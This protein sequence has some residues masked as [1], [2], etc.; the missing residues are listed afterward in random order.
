M[1]KYTD[2]ELK[3]IYDNI[4]I[5]HA[6]NEQ[7]N[8]HILDYFDK[9]KVQHKPYTLKTGDYSFMIK[10]IPKL[11]IVRDIYFDNSI[12]IERKANL[13]ELSNNI[14][15][16]RTRFT[17]EL[18]RAKF[19]NM[20]FIIALEQGTWGDLS[21]HRYKTKYDN[22][23]FI[24]TLNAFQIDY[25]VHIEMI[26]DKIAFGHYIKKK[27]EMYAKRYFLATEI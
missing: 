23:R 9:K 27:F 4:V 7:K 18:M 22:E 24:S 3:E 14:G 11:G 13:E 5:L 15:N 2:K 19:K 10:A 6:K 1:Y 20:L 26:N 16:D 12:A 21:W 8:K 25:N 17:D